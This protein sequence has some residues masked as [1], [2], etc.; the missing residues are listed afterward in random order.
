MSTVVT[1]MAADAVESRPPKRARTRGGNAPH[2]SE[3]K[4]EP[5]AENDANLNKDAVANDD[6][7]R[8]KRARSVP[9]DD[10][11]GQDASAAGTAA[12]SPTTNRAIADQEWRNLAEDVSSTRRMV[13]GAL[14]GKLVA[15]R[16]RIEALRA[17]LRDTE[18]ASNEYKSKWLKEKEQNEQLWKRIEEMRAAM[19]AMTRPIA[20]S[21][22]S[23]ASKAD[24]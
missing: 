9:S 6:K 16:R 2:A 21:V 18:K 3:S 8:V 22:K 14:R 19:M 1:S 24:T 15:Q 23:L 17:A 7:R 20:R 5:G 13:D 10:S 12:D 4:A 11:D